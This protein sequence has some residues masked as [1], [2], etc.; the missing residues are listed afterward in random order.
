MCLGYI[1]LL[2]SSK[3]NK[4]C[5]CIIYLVAVWSSHNLM[6]TVASSL[7]NRLPM[8]KN[9]LKVLLSLIEYMF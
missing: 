6:N 9:W 8:L 1:S 5:V 3:I 7:V 4:F 2:T